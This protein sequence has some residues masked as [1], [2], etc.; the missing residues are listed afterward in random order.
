MFPLQKDR[1]RVHCGGARRTEQG[2]VQRTEADP[3]S[4]EH[5]Q[6]GT[7]GRGEGDDTEGGAQQRGDDTTEARDPCG[8]R[9]EPREGKKDPAH[10]SSQPVP[11]KVH[12]LVRALE[13]ARRSISSPLTVPATAMYSCGPRPLLL[14]L[15]QGR[16]VPSSALVASTL[17]PSDGSRTSRNRTLASPT[18][19]V[20]ATCSRGRA[21]PPR[22]RSL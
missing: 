17:T 11:R 3:R 14:P 18:R 6:G 2:A 20:G 10:I 9:R 5:E 21:L 22:S 8:D 15:R 16:S 19:G 13:H 7:E 1:L 4:A 12:F